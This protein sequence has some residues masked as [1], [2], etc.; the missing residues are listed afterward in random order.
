M[1]RFWR[2][3]LGVGAWVACWSAGEVPGG[4]REVSLESLLSE[5]VDRDAAAQWPQPEYTCRQA[6]SYDRRS[7]S[8]ADAATWFANTDNMDGAGASLRW[9]T[10]QGRREC[11]LLDVEGPG[12]VVR[13]WSGGQPPKGVLRFYLDGVEPPAIE[14]PMAELMSGKA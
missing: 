6:S 14:A 10:I 5:M 3:A 7:K 11:V 12:C 4:E 9:E 2:V 13:F 1:S 8:P